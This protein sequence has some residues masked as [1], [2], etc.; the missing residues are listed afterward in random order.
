[1]TQDFVYYL[2]MVVI[3][4]DHGSSKPLQ[5]IQSHAEHA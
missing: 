3:S 4:L 1:M 5:N 2:T